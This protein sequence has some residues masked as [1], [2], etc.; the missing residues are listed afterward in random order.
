MDAQITFD[1]NKFS[2]LFEI[3][4]QITAFGK[5]QI[6]SLNLKDI[7]TAMSELQRVERTCEE[8]ELVS[9]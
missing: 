1:I 6:G 9:A 2:D 5:G 7:Q 4:Q 8:V 3:A